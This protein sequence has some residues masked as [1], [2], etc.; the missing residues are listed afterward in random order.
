MRKIF[1]LIFQII[2]AFSIFSASYNLRTPNGNENY[3]VGNQMPIH[4]DVTG[5]ATTSRLE[6]SIDG[7]TNW[8]LIYSSTQMMEIIYGQFQTIHL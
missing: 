6:Y 1:L 7:G 4:W 2:F 8:V 3:I 5:S